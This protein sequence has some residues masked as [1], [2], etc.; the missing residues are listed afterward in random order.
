MYTFPHKMIRSLLAFVLAMGGLV[1]ASSPALAASVTINLCA[2]AGTATLTGAVT[3]PIWGFGIPSTPGDCTTATASLPGP[4]LSVNEGDSV[5]VNV[6]NALP[7]TRTLTFEAPGIPFASGPTDAAAGATVTRTFT[8]SSP[9]TYVY[10]SG[11]DAGRQEA[12]GLYGALI[13]RSLTAGQAYD[14]A[15]TAY[16]VEATLVLSQV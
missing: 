2:V 6:T 9:G 7:G 12:M 14:S 5:T 10:Q 8:A 16:D 4:V 1:L 3:V 13:V 15:T 11:G